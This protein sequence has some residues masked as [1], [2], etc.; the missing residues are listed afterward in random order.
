MSKR[1]YL[2]WKSRALWLQL[3]MLCPR[4]HG[5]TVPRLAVQLR[6]PIL[7]RQ[8]PLLLCPDNPPPPKTSLVQAPTMHAGTS[9]ATVHVISSSETS[10]SAPTRKSGS[11]CIK[12]K[13]LSAHHMLAEAAK[14]SRE[15]LAQEMKAMAEANCEL[16]SMKIDVQLKLFTEQMD[17][18]RE[19]DQ[20]LY[21]NA[22]IA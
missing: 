20:R 17:Y 3:R 11:T 10:G 7:V 22:R 4:R 18:Q 14:S 1:T 21:E 8:H 2:V 9:P 6:R 19:K 12:Q 16:E 13:N 5:L 15:F